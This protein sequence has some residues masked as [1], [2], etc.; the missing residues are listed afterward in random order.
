MVV[1]QTVGMAE[2]AIPI[3]HMGK[4]GEELRPIAVIHHNVLPGIAPTG[5]MIDGPG[6][7]KTERTCHGAGVYPSQM[8]DCKT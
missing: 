2:P 5:D 8:Y 6:E 7:F 1:H 4:E 3:D